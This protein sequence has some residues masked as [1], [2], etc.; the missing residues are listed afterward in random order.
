MRFIGSRLLALSF[1]RVRA[2]TNVILGVTFGP[3][4]HR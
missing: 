3:G 2:D 1:Q 4:E